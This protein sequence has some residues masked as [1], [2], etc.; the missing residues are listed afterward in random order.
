MTLHPPRRREFLNQDGLQALERIRVGV[1]ATPD[2]QG[3]CEA[4]PLN[5]VLLDGDLW[6]HT[7]PH[8][9]LAQ[10]QQASFTGWCDESWIPSYWRHPQQACPATT[11]Y[12]SV[13]VRGRLVQENDPALKARV[14]EAFMSKYQPEG[15]HL[16]LD[17]NLKLYAGPLAE[18]S[19]L[20]L[21]VE[22]LSC[23]AKYG[24]HLTPAVRE[25]VRAGLV[26]RGDV[27][28]ADLMRR[29]NPGTALPE[30]YSDDASA[31]S[32][33]AI[34]ELLQPTYWSPK[35]SLELVARNRL[36]A[37]CQWGYF[38]EGRLLGY[39]RVHQNWLYDVIVHPELRGQGLGSG[40]MQRLMADPR[41]QALPF[42]G[43]HTRDA[44]P[45]YARFGFRRFHPDSR[46]M[47]HEP[48]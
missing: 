41:V 1:L 13:V 17:P 36:Q 8:S 30:G 40:L 18:L 7:S 35:R 21:V 39:L 11:Y 14:L 43:L 22:D 46:I 2:P 37:L 4:R 25:K 24:Q 42:L 12:T 47:I 32:A 15:G 44:H 26:G 16:A 27:A 19:V 20:R 38:R 45:F 29:H 6:F 48:G 28:I 3:G 10:R 33:E 5:F 9:Q 23:K 31:M 34:W